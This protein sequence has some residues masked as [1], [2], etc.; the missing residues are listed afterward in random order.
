MQT[1]GSEIV[2]ALERRGA[3]L[4]RFL[5]DFTGRAFAPDIELAALSVPR[6]S[7]KTWYAGNLAALAV[8]PDSPLFEPGREVLG[9]SASLEQ[10]RVMLQF[11]REAL[12]SREGDYRWLD[13]G[14][15]LAVT[16]KASG[17]KLR[18]LSS[19]GKRA[20]GL[21]NFGTIFADEPGSWEARGGALLWDALRT[22]LG[23]QGGQRLILIGTRAPA[24]A[25]SWWPVLLETGSGPGTHIE[26]RTAPDDAP[27]DAWSTIRAVNPMVMLNASLRKTILRERDEA[28]RN[29]A[30]RP[31]F[32][33]YRLNRQVDVRTEVLIAADAWRRV[34]ARAVPE[35]EG[36]A[37]VG[38]DV[39]AER[40]WS[41]AWCLWQNGRVEAYALC[42][43][44]P[45]LA[46][47]ERQDAM[48]AG[49][50]RRLADA[51]VL[52]VDEG[53]RMGRIE[54]LVERL[55]ASGIRPAT[56]YCDRFLIGQLT[57]AVAGRAP[58][59]PRR[60]RW[61]EA[62]EDI[63]AFRRMALD[64]PLAVEPRCLGLIRVGLAAAAVQ[65]DDQG[66]VRLVK[67]QTLRSRD[68]VAVAGVLAAG[69]WQ[70]SLQ[71]PRPRF[72]Y[73]GLAG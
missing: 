24:P 29:D 57:D 6:G 14:Q 11:C 15:R 68:D 66:S 70:R 51:G 12:A 69:G 49:L 4:P 22:S 64:G 53:R 20:M 72:R 67:R 42:P 73:A 55:F 50:Y 13:S 34:E 60:T 63:A 17:A 44:V 16:H 10:S 46:E 18:I 40:S 41:A 36:R 21:A 39:G 28:R 33:A 37:L 7:A 71:R 23:K 47:R 48:P 9:V 5:A 27:W 19:S 54:V 2:A 45:D 61:S 1:L 3:R 26:V 32:E 35:R 52:M 38:V 25:D 65:S 62:S 56:V 58:I 43:G 31:A 8:T 30:L 59:V